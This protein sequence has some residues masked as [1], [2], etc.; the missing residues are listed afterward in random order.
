MGRG[1][2]AGPARTGIPVYL[3]MWQSSPANIASIALAADQVQWRY[4]IC[5]QRDVCD[6]GQWPLQQLGGDL[7]M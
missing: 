3:R 1:R 4:M 5:H 7:L 2:D 6:A